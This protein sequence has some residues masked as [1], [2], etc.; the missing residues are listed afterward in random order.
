MGKNLKNW[1]ILD[2]RELFIVPQRMSV[3]AHRVELPNG[4]IYQPY[5]RVDLPDQA[6]VAA[7]TDDERFICQRQYKHGPRCVTLSLPGGIV[8]P[9]ESP[10]QTIQREL[11][12][13]T[14]YTCNP[15]THIASLCRNNNQHCGQEHF[16]CASG[17]VWQQN[18]DPSHN[19]EE[20]ETLLLDREDLLDALRSKDINVMGQMTGILLALYHAEISYT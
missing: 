13:E 3:A 8:D 5:Y 6:W 7:I 9:G 4:Q 14:G 2:S 20:I 10:G 16:F 12:E 17:A 11:L 1:K 18:P 19:L 15:P